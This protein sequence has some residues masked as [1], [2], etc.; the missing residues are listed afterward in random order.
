MTKVSIFGQ[1][2]VKEK[3]KIEFLNCFNGE[4]LSSAHAFPS[5]YANVT[6]LSK[7][8]GVNAKDVMLAWDT[9]E[10][11]SIYIGHWNDGVV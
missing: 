9:V 1:P 10:T 8:Y 4:G 7:G 6:L 2:E 5:D 3:K 11:G